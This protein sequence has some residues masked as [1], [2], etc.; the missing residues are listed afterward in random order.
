MRF[1]CNGSCFSN[2]LR[3]GLA[4]RRQSA[5][6]VFLKKYAIIF[7]AVGWLAGGDFSNYNS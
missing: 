5:T 2:V 4:V 6:E 3:S 1:D 7:V